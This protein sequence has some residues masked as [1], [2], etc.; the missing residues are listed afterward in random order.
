MTKP[1]VPSDPSDRRDW[2]VAALRRKGSSMRQIAIGLGVCP[3]AVA[4][5]LFLPS[6]RIENALADKLDVPVQVLFQERYR[7]DGTRL[8]KTRPCAPEREAA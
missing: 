8:C 5:A 1:Q 2:V 7:P 6:A 4:Q 3:Q